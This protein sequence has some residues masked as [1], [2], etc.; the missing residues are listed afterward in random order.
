MMNYFRYKLIAPNGKPSSGLIKLPYQDEIS[1]A[2]YLER[3]GSM[4]I[5][6]SKLG[7]LASLFS[8]LSSFRLFKRLKRTDQVELLNNLSLLLRSGMP[9]TTSLEEA[10]QATEHPGLASKVQDI[11]AAIQGGMSFSEA[12]TKFSDIFTETV[13]CLIRIGEET[14]RLDEM[15]KDASDHVNRVH[16]IISDTKRALLYPVFVF[17]SI[18]FGLAFWLYYV[19]PKILELF[20]EMNVALPTIT[21]YL[22]KVSDFFQD[23]FVGLFMGFFLTLV[24]L[25]AARKGSR[26]FRKIID[27]IMIKLPVVGAIVTA[28]NLAHITEYFSLLMK[29]G[30]NI[31]QA[32]KILSESVRNEIYRDKLSQV[33]KALKK[34]SSISEAFGEAIVFPTFVIRMISVGEVSGTLEDQLGHISGEYS[35]RLSNL[36]SMIGKMIEPIVLVVAGAIFAVI[37][38]ALLLPVY[39]MVSQVGGM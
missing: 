33:R 30:I 11:V 27:W 38:L 15:L 25:F 36:V 22:L 20:K 8:K 32:I 1:T 12:A 18:G 16:T 37:F 28:S 19:V 14:G 21:V 34:G 10:A 6:V 4:A 17:V 24:G 29:A 35:K 2:L 39:D 9:L 26:Q 23:Y 13:I 3:N 5:H 31:L 7:K